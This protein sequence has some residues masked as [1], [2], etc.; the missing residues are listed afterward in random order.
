MGNMETKKERFDNLYKETSIWERDGQEL[1]F[2]KVEQHNVG[3]EIEIVDVTEEGNL[4]EL[5]SIKMFLQGNY[6]WF[7]EQLKNGLEREPTGYDYYG[8]YTKLL[9]RLTECLTDDIY[10]SINDG[11]ADRPLDDILYA[12]EKEEL[13]LDT[14]FDEYVAQFEKP[15]DVTGALE[16]IQEMP[17]KPKKKLNLTKH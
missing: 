14:V 1:D 8:L 12:H 4:E 2:T 6:R 11:N 5:E 10:F 17:V 7:F 15:E 3:G 13:K 16:K 9:K